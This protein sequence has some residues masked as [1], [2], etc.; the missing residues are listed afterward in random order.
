[1]AAQ[2]A[3]PAQLEQLASRLE[4]TALQYEDCGGRILKQVQN[5]NWI[6]PASDKFVHGVSGFDKNV[7]GA[8][9][10]LRQL[11][12]GLRTGAK[13]I[14]DAQEAAKKKDD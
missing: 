14:R 7:K 11:A 12:D 1:M 8:G 2:P 13:S 9:T 5:L 4:R 3:D 6:G 10:V